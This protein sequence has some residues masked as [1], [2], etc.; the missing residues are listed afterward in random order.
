VAVCDVGGG[1]T[2]IA[3]GPSNGTAGWTTS[4]DLGSLRLSRRIG[5]GDPPRVAH[6]RGC[7]REVRAAVQGLSVPQTHGALATGGTAR[8]LK[9][10]V[11]TRLGPDEL[12][13]AF[14]ELSKRPAAEI[15]ARYAVPAWRARLLP[16]GAVILSEMQRLIGHPLLVARGGLREGAAIELGRRLAAAA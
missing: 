6:L 15:S 12:Q 13:E 1:S 3:V 16:A 5:P 9:K 10:L 14:A 7:S 11:G 8:A 2:Q 4:I